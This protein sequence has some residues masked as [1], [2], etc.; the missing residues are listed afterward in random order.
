MESGIFAIVQNVLAADF[1]TIPQHCLML[2][3]L[4]SF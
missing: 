3:D 2:L 1:A 4:P